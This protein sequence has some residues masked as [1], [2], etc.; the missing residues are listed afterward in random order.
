MKQTSRGCYAPGMF[1]APRRLLLISLAAGW[2]LQAQP[3]ARNVI[4]VVG[5]GMG[6][7]SLNAASILAHQQP[8]AL[9]LHRM[10]GMAFAAT[11]STSHWVTDAGAA[12]TAF[13]TGRATANR[14][15]SAFP[16]SQGPSGGQ[17]DLSAKTLLDY[18]E[19]R[20]LATG[21]ISDANLT[22]PLLAAFYARQA[23]RSDL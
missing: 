18:A 23:N 5:D 2:C 9:F 21:G 13:A 6:L 7:T 20:G 8:Q 14:M 15:L 19:E 17:P 12:A 10:P 16:A 22:N 1:S 4:L 3:S 11:A